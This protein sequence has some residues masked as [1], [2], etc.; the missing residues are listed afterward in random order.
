MVIT[1]RNQE[2]I[3]T[4]PMPLSATNGHALAGASQ[5]TKFVA[6]ALFGGSTVDVTIYPNGEGHG[7]IMD[8][9]RIEARHDVTSNAVHETVI[10]LILNRMSADVR[11]KLA[12]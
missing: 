9:D 5:K 4:V 3:E 12:K 10:A 8:T 7:D 6:K 1:D 11:C 2:V